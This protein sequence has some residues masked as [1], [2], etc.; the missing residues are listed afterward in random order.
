[1]N[2]LAYTPF[3]DA[4]PLHDG[5]YLL[6]IPMTIFLAIG[7]KGVRCTHLSRYPREVAIFIAQ[8][9]GVI[10]LLAVGFLVLINFLI[11]MLAPM[12]A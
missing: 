10:I 2:T 6:I 7:Y 3:I 5:W 1:M 9:L 12:P 4:L 8:I 11:P